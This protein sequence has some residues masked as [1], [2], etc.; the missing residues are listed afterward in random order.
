MELAQDHVQWTLVLVVRNLQ[1]QDMLQCQRQKPNKTLVK[2]QFV[3]SGSY[4]KQRQNQTS[5]VVR[6]GSIIM[7]MNRDHADINN[8]ATLSVRYSKILPVL[9]QAPH[10]KMYV[11]VVGELHTFSSSALLGGE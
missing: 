8:C 4:Q 9:N 3:V 10:M 7:E 11:G 2:D 6:A 5:E 1:G